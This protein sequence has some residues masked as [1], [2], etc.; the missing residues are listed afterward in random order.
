MVSVITLSSLAQREIRPH[1]Y[2]GGKGGVSFSRVNFSPSVP[3]AMIIGSVVGVHVKYSEEQ[4]FG[5]I[6]ELNFEQ[7]GWKESFSDDAVGLTYSR[8][9]NF[10]Q[11]PVL[12]NIFFGSERARFFINL[13][14]EIGIMVSNSAKSNFDYNNP[15]ST[16]PSSHHT[17]QYGMSIKNRFDYGISA[18][19]GVEVNIGK[20]HCILLEG[21]FYY[22]LNNCFSSHKSDN[23]SSSQ[24]MSIMANIGYFFRLK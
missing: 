10:I 24:S 1:F 16:I 5:I 23:F 22:G 3:Q 20:K 13:G 12:A 14:P 15:P 7:R 6:G 9:F 17:E 8:T 2:I 19:L 21:R 11:I 18:G 4:H